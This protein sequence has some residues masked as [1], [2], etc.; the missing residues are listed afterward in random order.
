MARKH[1]IKKDIVPWIMVAKYH[2]DLPC[3][4]FIFDENY[5]PLSVNVLHLCRFLERPDLWLKSLSLLS[6]I[7]LNLAVHSGLLV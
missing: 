6:R 1:N 5:G 4:N 3:D 7:V 2:I